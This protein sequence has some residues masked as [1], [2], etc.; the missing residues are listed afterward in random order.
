V[1]PLNGGPRKKSK[2]RV[3]GG[4][5][6]REGGGSELTRRQAA[7]GC[8]RKR[9][10]RKILPRDIERNPGIGG[11]KFK[12]TGG[13]KK[14]GKVAIFTRWSSRKRLNVR[15]DMGKEEGK[16]ISLIQMESSNGGTRDVR[17]MGIRRVGFRGAG[18]KKG[19]AQH[20]GPI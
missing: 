10:T 13:W 8:M 18:R 11:G 14:G 7:R 15:E 1:R 2:V 16:A 5:G 12:I 9:R 6:E 3:E 17:G 19:W 20:G 4:R